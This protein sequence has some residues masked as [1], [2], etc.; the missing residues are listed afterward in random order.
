M[1]F[2]STCWLMRFIFWDADCCLNQQAVV[3]GINHC[4]FRPS[5]QQHWRVLP[6]PQ[7][8][9]SRIFDRWVRQKS[10]KFKKDESLKN[11]MRY[12]PR[13]NDQKHFLL[14]LHSLIVP[15]ISAKWPLR[16]KLCLVTVSILVG[17]LQ[18]HLAIPWKRA[19]IV[20][21]GPRLR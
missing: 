11:I 13:N 8:F 18:R 1:T 6:T 3:L 7:L 19:P 10:G 14:W 15:C 4:Y 12:S 17:Y 21:I 9:S 20:W 2:V 16:E 5:H